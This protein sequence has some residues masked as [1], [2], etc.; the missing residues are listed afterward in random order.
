MPRKVGAAAE[1]TPDSAIIAAKPTST[2][3]P[4]HYFT[5][6]FVDKTKDFTST[7]KFDRLKQKKA[8]FTIPKKGPMNDGLAYLK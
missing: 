2:I 4:F 6:F 8:I 3:F 5:S 7:L 1:A